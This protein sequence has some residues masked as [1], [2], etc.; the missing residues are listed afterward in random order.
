MADKKYTVMIIEDEKMTREMI[1]MQLKQNSYNAIECADGNEAIEIIKSNAN[2]DLIVIDYM[3][4]TMNGV[5]TMT[6]IKEELGSSHPFI[7]LTGK[8]PP[9]G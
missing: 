6:K 4:P 2:I 5:E 3:M 9:L 8:K 1:A 7:M